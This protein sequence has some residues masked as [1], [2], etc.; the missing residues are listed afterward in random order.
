MLDRR[1]IPDMKLAL[2]DLRELKDLSMRWGFDLAQR[3]RD[4]GDAGAPVFQANIDDVRAEGAGD[5]HVRYQIADELLG[6][7]A[8]MRARNVHSDVINQCYTVSP[9]DSTPPAEG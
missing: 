6:D 1:Y 9:P 7:L 5:R 4:L 2:S 3:L 8:A